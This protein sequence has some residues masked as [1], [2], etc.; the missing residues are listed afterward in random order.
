MDTVVI[1]CGDCKKF[2]ETMDGEEYQK[3]QKRVK[4]IEGELGEGK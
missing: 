3:L 4:E 1:N 2:I